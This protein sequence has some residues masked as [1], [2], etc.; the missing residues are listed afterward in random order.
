MRLRFLLL[1]ILLALAAGLPV[2]A[3]GPHD[4]NQAQNALSRGEIQP[5]HRILPQVEQ[6]F[7]ARLLEVEL[8]QRNGRLIYEMKLIK[9]NGRIFEAA[10]DAATGAIR[11]G[12][13]EDED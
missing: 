1:S 10:V 8:E 7:G 9:P 3:R 13:T 4:H 6:R 2:V 5:L 11:P 12:D